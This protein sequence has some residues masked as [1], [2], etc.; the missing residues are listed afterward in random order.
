MKKVLFSFVSFLLA[1]SAMQAQT[2]LISQ[3][4]ESGPST[5][6]SYSTNPAAFSVGSDIWTH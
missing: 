5:G 4:F 3:G 1:S 6:W 2:T